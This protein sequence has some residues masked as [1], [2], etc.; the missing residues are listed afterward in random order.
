VAKWT[1]LWSPFQA[2]ADQPILF[3]LPVTTAFEALCWFCAG[4]PAGDQPKSAQKAN[5]ETTPFLGFCRF[6]L[7]PVALDFALIT[8]RSEVQI[9]P[10]QLRPVDNPAFF[11][12]VTGRDLILETSGVRI[13]V[14]LVSNIAPSAW[15]DSSHRLRLCMV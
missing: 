14:I 1:T 4:T 3:F 8:Q 6:V 7:V 13:P 12:A 11:V 2:R 9:L 15:Q 5:A 10:P